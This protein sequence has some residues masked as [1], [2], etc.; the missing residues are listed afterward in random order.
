VASRDGNR[1]RAAASEVEAH[2]RVV[3]R[4]PGK[5]IGE[6][7]GNFGDA[8][9]TSSST[10]RSKSLVSLPTLF[11][12]TVSRQLDGRGRDIGKPAGKSGIRKCRQWLSAAA[13]IRRPGRPC[14]TTPRGGVRRTRAPG[15]RPPGYTDQCRRC[16]SGTRRSLRRGAGRHLRD[17]AETHDEAIC[18]NGHGS[19]SRPDED[20]RPRSRNTG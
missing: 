17:G 4:S 8:P 7:R 18:R 19:G 11:G 10:E 1:T 6:I 20:Q 9:I 13:P 3:T 15:P 12:S 2:P 5:A 14:P 16:P